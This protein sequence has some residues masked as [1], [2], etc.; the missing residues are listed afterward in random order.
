[1]MEGKQN[2]EAGCRISKLHGYREVEAVGKEICF[3]TAGNSL[4]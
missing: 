2:D 4:L 1:M 3:M